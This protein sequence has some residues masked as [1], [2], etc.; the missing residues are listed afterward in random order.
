[1]N[2]GDFLR[3]ILAVANFPENKRNKFIEIFY[4][5]YYFRLIDEI[6]GVDPAYGQRLTTAVD[7]L[8]TDPGQFETVW[9]ELESNVE[10]KQKI[11]EVTDE[12]I[13][14]LVSDIEKSAS[15][16]EKAQILSMV[17]AGQNL[18]N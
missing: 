12:V 2:F 14:Y 13:G 3:K 1:M 7:N 17:E 18:P 11:D 16:E 5:Y 4:Q 15:D 9:R 8:E 10:F 6:G